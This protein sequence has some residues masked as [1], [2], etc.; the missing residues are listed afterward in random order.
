M[1]IEGI[2]TAIVVVYIKRT[3]AGVFDAKQAKVILFP[4]GSPSLCVYG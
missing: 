3:D 2:L 4:F 1:F